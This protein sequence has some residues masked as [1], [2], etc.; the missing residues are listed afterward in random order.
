VVSQPR[1]FSAGA[2]II[3]MD[4]CYNP[5]YAAG[6]DYVSDGTTCSAG[7][8]TACYA[9]YSTGNVRLPFGL[10]YLLAVNN[11]PVN[12]ILNP[13]KRGLGDPDFSVTPYAGATNQTSSY[14]AW[15]GSAYAV[16]PTLMT[17]GT[18]TVYYGGMPFVVDGPYADQALQLITQFNAAHGNLF[19]PVPLHIINYDFQA[20]VLGVMASRPK[21]VAIDGPPLDTYFSES[22]ITSV[23]P[24]GS[25]YVTI[26]GTAPNFSFTWPSAAV[27]PNP[28]CPGDNCTSLTWAG[29]PAIKIVDVIWVHNPQ[30]N[31][32]SDIGTFYNLGGTALVVADATQWETNGPGVGGTIGPAANGAQKGPYCATDAV[33][34]ANLNAQPGPTNDYPASNKFLQ[35]GDMSL[36]VHGVGGGDASAY[37][38]GSSPATHTHALTNTVNYTAIAGH[39]MVNGTQAPGDVVYLGSL[40]SWH[41]GAAGKDAGLHI[42][43]NTLLVGGDGGAS[44][45][46]GLY[47]TAG[48][49]SGVE[50]S[51]SGPVGRPSGEYY[52]GTFDWLIPKYPTLAGN[53]L[54]VPSLSNYPYVTGHF[55]E[56]KSVNTANA[57]QS[58]L[59]N[60][61]CD[62]TDPNSACNWDLADH[63]DAWSTRQNK[64]FVGVK[65]GSGATATYTMTAA[66]SLAG[67][68][69]ITFIGNNIG[70]RLGGVDWASG[71]YIEQKPN[72]SVTGAKT[73]PPVA[74]VGARDG[75][76]HAICADPNGCYGQPWK[77]ELWAF[78]PPSVKTQMDYARTTS[79]DWSQINVGGSIRAADVTDTFTGSTASSK[80]V[81]LVGTREGSSVFALEVS[82]PDPSKVNQDGNLKL[83]WETDAVNNIATG[84]TAYPMGKT[85]G[86]VMATMVTKNTVMAVVTSNVNG[87]A[88][89]SG[90]NTYLLRITNGQVVSSNQKLFTRR[91]PL[92]G[93]STGLLANDVP[94][95][96][97][98]VDLDGD[99]TDE[100]VIV[101]DAEGIVREL[102][103]DPANLV[104]SGAPTTVFDTI[105]K[106]ANSALSCQPIGASASIGRYGTASPEPLAAFVGTGGADWARSTTVHSYA[107]GFALGNGSTQPGGA[108]ILDRDLGTVTPPVSTTAGGTSNPMPLR[109]YSQLSIAGTDLYADTTTLSLGNMNQMVLPV[110]YPG[111]YGQIERWGNL[112]TGTIDASATYL[113]TQGQNFSGGI[114]AVLESGST[115]TQGE[116]TF[117]GTSTTD[118]IV[119]Q[120]NSSS[121]KNSAYAVTQTSG[122]R[123]FTVLTWFDLGY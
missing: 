8:L 62:E 86:A 105:S 109:A 23:V 74:Y 71:A 48:P 104:F 106:C 67:D 47:P 30:Y 59:I 22:G 5:D 9:N 3:P 45:T 13:T 25:T 100:T 35:I 82:N 12:I 98:T 89:Q 76:L 122:S 115:G 84:V 52:V 4:Q 102:K 97:T 87:T 29:P 64:V 68:A 6:A 51:R 28:G 90:L 20:P 114:G 14:V 65:S 85:R 40:N 79:N 119:L 1:P 103:I 72:S 34:G 93:G 15:N 110:L 26:N 92:A 18:N 33:S 44:N 117:T 27:G 70:A 53:Q 112:N 80:T 83:L 66:S 38:F 46:P 94:P 7:A 21:P 108:T 81:L 116:L 73:R 77:T 95:A 63:I 88:A 42:M 43:Y 69:T 107:L 60:I 113:I 36:F 96:A 32:W 61:Y 2:L 120:A 111:T 91:E 55:R 37:Q 58:G 123:L 41:G 99:G 10:L 75:M 54:Y 17:C 49:F 121:L 57:G 78:I 11:I 50:L 24:N 16:S 31:Q 118:R 19:A 101:P 39:P 56:F